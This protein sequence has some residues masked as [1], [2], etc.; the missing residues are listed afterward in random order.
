MAVMAPLI[1][2]HDG[3]VHRDTVRR[4]KNF[5][6]DIQV[7]W[8]RMAQSVIRYNVVIVGKF[9]NKGSW[10]SEAW[11]KE[12]PEDCE[13][14]YEGPPERIA[15]AEERREK[16]HL[17]QGHESAVCVR[18]PGTPPPHGVRLTSAGMGT[19]NLQNVRTNLPT[20]LI[21][22][23][24]AQEPLKVFVARSP[25]S[26]KIPSQKNMSIINRIDSQKK[27]V[28]L[29]C[30]GVMIVGPGKIVAIDKV[31]LLFENKERL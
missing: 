20:Q 25:P 6:P 26:K 23:A 7:D 24:F 9:F 11:R 31:H 12:H 21:S 2:S 15:S 18:S 22:I 29:K 27:I 16:L 13:N 17:D 28:E 1:I 3:A 14:E 4:W 30:E 19:P 8:V 10:V 5:A